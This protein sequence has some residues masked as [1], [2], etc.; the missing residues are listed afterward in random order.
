MLNDIIKFVYPMHCIICDTVLPYGEGLENNFLCYDCRKKIEFINEPRCRKC[1][2]MISDNDEMYCERCLSQSF[3]SFEYGIGLCRYNDAVKESLHK[4]K[5]GG[6]KEYIDFYGKC[7]A[8]KYYKQIYQMSAECMVP[9]PIHKKRYIKRGYNQ[10]AVLANAISNELY[11]YN[12]NLPVNEELIYR[13]KNT[14]VL[15]KLANDEREN[16][17]LGAFIVD[18]SENVESV[19]LVDDIYTTGSTIS[20]IATQLKNNGIKRVYFISIAVVDNL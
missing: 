16:E 2:A 18:N 14:N 11:N 19:I 1:G 10:A 15:N 6:R 5:Y 3:D 13:V 12:I 9:I 8:K 7:I 4:I 20:A 17:L